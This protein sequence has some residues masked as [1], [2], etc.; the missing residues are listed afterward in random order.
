MCVYNVPVYTHLYKIVLIKDY[1]PFQCK[2]I[3]LKKLPQT[4]KFKKTTLSN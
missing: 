3:F 2:K 1:I 4:E